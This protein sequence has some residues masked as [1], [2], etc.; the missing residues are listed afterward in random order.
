MLPVCI[1]AEFVVST[2]E[3]L[4]EGVSGALSRP[5]SAWTGLLAYSSA[6]WRVAGSMSS[7][8]CGWAAADDLAVLVD[9]SGTHAP[10]AH[11]PAT[12]DICSSTD[13]RSPGAWRQGR[14]H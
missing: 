14:Q 3:V 11:R 7:S 8:A 6:M 5:W 13:Q 10:T 1:H 9:R 12:L 2:V 4:D